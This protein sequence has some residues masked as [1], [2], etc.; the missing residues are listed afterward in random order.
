MFDNIIKSLKKILPGNKS[1]N[2]NELRKEMKISDSGISLIK[3]FEG[4]RLQSYQDVV[5][6]WTIGVG[7][8]DPSIGPNQTITQEQ[9]DAILRADLSKFESGVSKLLKISVSQDQFDALVCFSFNVGLKALADSTLLKLLNS[10]DF[11]GASAQFERWD[12]AGG[13]PVPGLTRR[14]LA[15]KSLFLGNKP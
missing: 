9:A 2:N 14:R 12:K 15:E 6:I 5:G 8:V 4:C 13:K 11:I 3:A 1:S 10:G 7:H